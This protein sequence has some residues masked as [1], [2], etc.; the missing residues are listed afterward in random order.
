MFGTRTRSRT[1][2]VSGCFFMEPT[3]NGVGSMY[4]MLTY[5]SHKKKPSVGKYAIHESYEIVFMITL[6][7]FHAGKWEK[8]GQNLASNHWNRKDAFSGEGLWSSILEISCMNGISILSWMLWMGFLFILI[9]SDTGLRK[10]LPHEHLRPTISPLVR[11]HMA[12]IKKRDPFC[13]SCCTNT[14]TWSTQ[15]NAFKKT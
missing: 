5:M 8:L 13:K 7:F 15:R 12:F 4:G 3:W 1:L 11:V 14:T 10:E 6:S 9:Y 2:Q